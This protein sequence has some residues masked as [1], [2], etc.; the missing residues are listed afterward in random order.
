MSCTLSAADDGKRVLTS[1]GELLG[2]LECTDDGTAFVRPRREYVTG[3]GSLLTGCWDR[4]D[5]FR[6]D[7][8]AVAAVEDRAVRIRVQ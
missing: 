5:S 1:D 4:V 7:E 8:S 2:W 6:L 3:Y